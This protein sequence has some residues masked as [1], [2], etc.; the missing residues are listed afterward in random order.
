MAYRR[1]KGLCYNC[2][3]KWGSS[4]RCKGRVL[5]FIANSDEPSSPESNPSE[6]LSPSKHDYDQASPETTQPFDPTSLHPHISLHA[7]AGVPATDT[8]RLYG[9]I[10]N[11]RVTILVDIGSTH[12]FVQPRV[13][14]FL[15]LPLRDTLPLRVM[16]GNGSVLDCQ[17]MIPDVMILIQDHSFVVTLRV[18]PLSG[19]DVVLG[20]EWLRTLGPVITDYTDFT[21][22]FTLFGRPIHLRADVQTDTS[23][24]STHQVKRLI[25]TNS[26][27]GLFHLSLQPTPSSELLNT[28][29]HP[30][31]AINE[32]LLKYQSIFEQPTSLPPPRPHG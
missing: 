23:P 27:S 8:F 31:P 29:P 21:M 16:V 10:N 5:F 2:D 6:P 26:T 7:M 13:A 28:T 19:A 11:T 18:L 17:Q 14:K 15:N 1:E 4:H 20:V 25:T 30:V 22:K 9:L 24:V 12:N 32:L 3:E